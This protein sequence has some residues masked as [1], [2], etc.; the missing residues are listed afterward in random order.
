MF[1][2]GEIF[3]GGSHNQSK[4]VCDPPNKGHFYPQ[5]KH[6]K[7]KNIFFH[8]NAQVR[9]FHSVWSQQLQKHF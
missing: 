4:S 6:L 2:S 1:F 5:K 7:K 3:F 8:I 9:I